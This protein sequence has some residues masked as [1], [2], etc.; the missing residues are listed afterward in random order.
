M[1]RLAWFTP[2]PPIRSGISR[3]SHELLPSLAADYHIDVFVDGRS[4]QFSPDSRVRVFDAHEFVWKHFRQSYD[5]VVYQLGN[6]RCH[7]Y[8][9]A[10]MTRVPGLVALHDGQ[11]HHARGRMLLQRFPPRQDDYRH[12]FWFNHPDANPDVA[13]LGAIGL[14]GSLTYLWPMLRL[15]VESSRRVLVHNDWLADQIREAHPAISVDVVEM[16]VPDSAP[17]SG[18]RRNIRARHGISENAVVFTAFGKATPEKRIREAIR[19][20]ASIADAVSQAHLLVA[21]ETDADYDLPAHAEAAGILDRVT[22]A[23]YVADEDIDDYLSASDVCLCMRWPTS[24]ETSASWLRSLAAGR[25]TISTDLV[26][27][28]DIPTLDPRDWSVL[29][30]PKAGTVQAEG[31]ADAHTK[32]VGISI[33]I[34]DENHSLKLAMRRLGTDENLR[35]SLGA[36]ARELWHRR[37]RLESMVAAYR[38]TITQTLETAAPN[39]GARVKLPPHLRSTGGEFADAL[40]EEVSGTS[41]RGFVVER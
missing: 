3:Y 10:Y 14:L 34:L 17:R 4:G 40:L 2:L 9:W 8:M 11:L 30:N 15:V 27:S 24:R 20:L 37:F 1:K 22:V 35:A 36:N 7:D 23:G 38:R 21:G 39:A 26:H 25:P 16:G 32:P 13:E 19:A 29:A 33:D 6:A 12:E 28:V 18:A 41:E 5:L 31:D